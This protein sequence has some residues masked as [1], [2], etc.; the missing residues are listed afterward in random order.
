VF[1]AVPIAAGEVV[2]ECPVLRFPAAQRAH[3]DATLIDEYYFDWDG[4]GAIALGLGSLYNHADEPVAEYIKD[5]AN[6]VLVVRALGA[7]AAGEEITF[8]YGPV[9]P[10]ED[11]G[12]DR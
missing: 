2:E 9:R 5:T 7:I 1:A 3:I 4:D 6:D 11:P 10:L 12:P 8:A